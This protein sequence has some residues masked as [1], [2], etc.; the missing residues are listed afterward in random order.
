MNNEDEP[1]QDGFD[2]ECY[3]AGEMEMGG[4]DEL[5][6]DG[7]DEDDNDD[8]EEAE[9][10]DDSEESNV[11]ESGIGHCR[12]CGAAVI[13]DELPDSI[14]KDASDDF[15]ICLDCQWGLFMD[16]GGHF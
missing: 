9:D 1:M 8:D 6:E 5:F 3:D 7:I 15:G 11:P 16:N 12:Y 10:D 2:E 14:S 4:K 13:V